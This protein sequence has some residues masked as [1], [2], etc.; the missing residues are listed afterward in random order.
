MYEVLQLNE[1]YCFI[2]YNFSIKIIG[3]FKLN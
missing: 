1:Q 3:E 2:P